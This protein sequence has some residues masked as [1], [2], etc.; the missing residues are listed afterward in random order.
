MEKDKDNFKN[1]SAAH[2]IFDEFKNDNYKFSIFDNINN[3]FE[4]NNEE[5][6]NINEEKLKQNKKISFKILNI[7]LKAN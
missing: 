7:F 1:E 3:S 5:N 2:P 4:K 6:E